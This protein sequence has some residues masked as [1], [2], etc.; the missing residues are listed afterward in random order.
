[1]TVPGFYLV[2][3]LSFVGIIKFFAMPDLDEACKK[4]ERDGWHERAFR[5]ECIK[6]FPEAAEMRGMKP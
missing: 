4:A 5:T 3:F 6:K 1:M 2:I